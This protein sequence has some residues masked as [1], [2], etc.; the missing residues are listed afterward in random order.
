MHGDMRS[1]ADGQTRYSTTIAI[2]YLPAIC[3]YHRLML[4]ESTMIMDSLPY[5]MVTGADRQ[6]KAK[7]GLESMIETTSSRNHL[8][9]WRR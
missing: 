9:S 6:A 3:E 7:I 5:L 2:V 4:D 8:G 1:V